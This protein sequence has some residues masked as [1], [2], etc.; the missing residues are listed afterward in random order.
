LTRVQKKEEIV[1]KQNQAL[2]SILALC[3]L[4]GAIILTMALISPS[5]PLPA[6]A[7]Q[8]VGANVKPL[9]PDVWSELLVAAGLKEILV[10]IYTINMQDEAKG[11][12]QR[13]G[14]GGSLAIMVRMLFL[15]ARS[16][17]YR[18]FAQGMRQGGVIPEN[19]EEYFGYGLFVEQK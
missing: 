19:L 18:K 11:I 9:A 5:G 4:A 1:N 17:A 3:I 15:C 8:D 13:Y 12:F 2:F 10:K 7:A 6:L 14:L 16:P